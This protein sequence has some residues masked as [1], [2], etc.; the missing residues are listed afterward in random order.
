[1]LSKIQ[2]G[3]KNRL[4]SCDFDENKMQIKGC[5]NRWFL[6]STKPERS[7]GRRWEETTG[8]GHQRWEET[9]GAGQQPWVEIGVGSS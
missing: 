3:I 7:P 5:R 9:T 4:E 8:E 1:M 2:F 6:G